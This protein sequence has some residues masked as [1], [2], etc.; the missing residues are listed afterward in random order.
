MKIE[1]S[2]TEQLAK[3]AHQNLHPFRRYLRSKLAPVDRP[4]E[5]FFRNFF[6]CIFGIYMHQFAKIRNKKIFD[7][8]P[9]MTSSWLD[10]QKI[11]RQKLKMKIFSMIQNGPIRKVIMLK[12][13]FEDI[14][15]ILVH[16]GPSQVILS[17]RHRKFFEKIFLPKM[18]QFA[19]FRTKIEK[20]LE[21]AS[22]KHDRQILVRYWLVH[23]YT[24]VCV[25]QIEIRGST[26]VLLVLHQTSLL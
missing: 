5:N 6:F 10:T 24:C 13:K 25:L 18:L 9:I 11:F 23:T 8:F 19:K 3:T 16:F 14:L 21:T 2:D 26:H 22:S 12:S 17:A 20:T 15:K 1:E 4:P 7:F